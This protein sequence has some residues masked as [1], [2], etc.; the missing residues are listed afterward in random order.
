MSKIRVHA[1]AKDLGIDSKDVIEMLKKQGF[2]VKAQSGL[3]DEQVA[4]LY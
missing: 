2:D 1:L 4:I 3:E